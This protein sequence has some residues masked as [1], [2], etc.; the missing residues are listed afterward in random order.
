MMRIRPDYPRRAR[1]DGIGGS[2]RVRFD[3]DPQGKVTNVRI[4]SSRPRGVFDRA[5]IKAVKRWR[6]S[7]KK[8]DGVGIWRRGLSVSLPFRL[9]N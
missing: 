8:V 7:P 9:R 5:V 4:T 1:Q 2:V 3:V 6:Y